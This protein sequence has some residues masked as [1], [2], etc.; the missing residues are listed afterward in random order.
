MIDSD[1]DVVV[2]G[3]GQAGLAAAYHLR[4]SG[5]RYTLL[6]STDRVGGSWRNHYASLRLLSPARY[7]SLPGLPFPG[8][9]E[10]YPVRDDVVDYLATYAR[11]VDPPVMTGAHVA[12]LERANGGETGFLLTLRDGPVIRAGQ[13]IVATGAFSLPYVPEIPGA[14][15]YTGT[16]IHSAGYIEPQRFAGRRMIVVGSGNTAVQVA[17]ELAAHSRTTLAARRMPSFVPQRLFGSDLH[18]WVIASGI[19]ALPLGAWFGFHRPEPVPDSGRYRP[20]LAA[21]SPDL[22]PMFRALSR[23]GVI[24]GDGSTEAVDTVIFATGYRPSLSFLDGL[25]EAARDTRPRRDTRPQ[26]EAWPSRGLHPATANYPVTRP[27][28]RSGGISREHPGLY[29]LGFPWQRSHRSGTIRGVGHD[30]RLIVGAVVKSAA[31]TREGVTR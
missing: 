12:R 8:D 6:E 17:C 26:E 28:P 7:A 11:F 16:T 14:G 10:H 20:A 23:D 3:A 21:G 29:Y 4:E 5:L 2:I 19:D 22:R 30:A 24:W 13:V 27:E 18:R 1:F 25:A 15:E 9:P 31:R